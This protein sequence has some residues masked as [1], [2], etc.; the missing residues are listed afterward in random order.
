[1]AL[2]KEQWK[3]LVPI[4]IVC[5]LGIAWVAYE[6]PYAIFG[7]SSSSDCKDYNTAEVKYKVQFPDRCGCL[8]PEQ[9]HALG[10]AQVRVAALACFETEMKQCRGWEKIGDAYRQCVAKV[11]GIAGK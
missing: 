7:L 9:A 8:Y 1:V 2:N 4:V 5:A 10:N 3:Q 11:T 6:H